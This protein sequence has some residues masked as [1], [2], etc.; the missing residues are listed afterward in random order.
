MLYNRGVRADLFHLPHVSKAYFRKGLRTALPR[1]LLAMGDPKRRSLT[2]LEIL[3]GPREKCVLRIDLIRT[4]TYDQT[5][6]LLRSVVRDL[7]QRRRLV[8]GLGNV[9]GESGPDSYR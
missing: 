5:V 3:P 4:Y 2:S 1:R 8:P 9:D 7:A 6:G